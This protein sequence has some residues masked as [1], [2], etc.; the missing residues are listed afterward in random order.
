M[1]WDTKFRIACLGHKAPEPGIDHELLWL[2]QKNTEAGAV[3]DGRL[4]FT[5][6]SLP[7]EI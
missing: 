2:K 3:T 1:T 7:R 6:K 4:Y 5:K